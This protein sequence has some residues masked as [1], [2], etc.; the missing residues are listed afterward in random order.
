M[1]SLFNVGEQIAVLSTLPLNFVTI[2]ETGSITRAADE[3]GLAKSAVSQSLKKLEAQLGIKLAVRTTR[4]LSLTPAGERYYR[5]CKDVLALA[6]QAATEMEAYGAI[7]SGPIK[8]TAPHVLIAPIIAPAMA[9]VMH[10]FPELEPTVI[11]DDARLD[12]IA[13]GIDVAIAVGVLRDSNLRARKIGSLRDI[14][15]VAPSL[16]AHAPPSDTPEFAKWVQGLPYIAH[17]REP[18]AVI[19]SIPTKDHTK[20]VTLKFNPSFCCNT[21]DAIAACTR[22]GLGVA[23]LPDIRVAQEIEDGS[24]VRLCEQLLPDPT[25]IHA[26]H[27]YDTLVP[28][29]VK[30]VIEAVRAALSGRTS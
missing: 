4:H 10:Q 21:L 5:R 14:L 15:C 25:P 8:I 28:R 24:L 30:E 2:V 19:H 20:P 7:P 22:E 13:E 27:T 6:K 23:F 9:K 18:S 16:M 1:K 12:L 26:V 3:L 29:S 17:L 11:A